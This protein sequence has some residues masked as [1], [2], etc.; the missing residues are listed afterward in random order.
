MNTFANSAPST[1]RKFK[2]SKYT[3]NKNKKAIHIF[4]TFRDPSYV[5]FRFA[6]L[7]ILLRAQRC[8]LNEVPRFLRRVPYCMT[9]RTLKVSIQS[10]DFPCSLRREFHESGCRSFCHSLGNVSFLCGLAPHTSTDLSKRL[11]K[12]YCQ[13]TIL[14]IIRCT[15]RGR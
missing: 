1:I 6:Y 12:R 9:T 10:Q 14:S 3:V 2:K 7:F 13:S 15:I 8:D 5:S 4:H 11:L